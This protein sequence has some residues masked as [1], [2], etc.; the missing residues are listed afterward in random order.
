MKELLK[1]IEDWK[2][3]SRLGGRNGDA[4]YTESQL[5]DC[6][7]L[8][9]NHGGLAPHRHKFHLGEAMTQ[10]SFPEMFGDI[11]N[12]RLEAEFSGVGTPLAPLFG[13]PRFVNDFGTIKTYRTEG[14]AY[15]LQRVEE[16]GEYKARKDEEAVVEWA[17]NKYGA[18]VDFSWEAW[19]RDNL[20]AF[21]RFPGKLARSAINT[22]GRI[23]TGIFFDANGPLNATFTGA[24]GQA[25]VSALPLT[26]ANLETAVEAMGSYTSNGEPILNGPLF[27]VT[28]PALEL[29]AK[30]I[31]GSLRYNFGSDD[32]VRMG[33][34]NTIASLSSVSVGILFGR[35]TS[36][37]VSLVKD[38]VTIK[39]MSMI[40]TTSSIGVRST[41]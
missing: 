24:G 18:Q 37:A 33:D 4:P 41:P 22:E 25:A 16:K 6:I 31:M 14:M 20:G 15:S 29:T 1:V 10:D 5:A 35:S 17:V 19:L 11:V 26:E 13:A 9:E 7:A 34:L 40:N 12:R 8:V 30:R 27:L 38:A 2:G 32:D 36:I 21:A 3:F 28:G 39:K 23:Q